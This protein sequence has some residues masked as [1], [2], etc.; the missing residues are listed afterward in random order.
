MQSFPSNYVG[1]ARNCTAARAEFQAIPP[2]QDSNHPKQERREESIECVC[3]FGAFVMQT[4]QREMHSF[5]SRYV[6]FE[7]NHAAAGAESQ[8]TGSKPSQPGKK[9]QSVE[10]VCRFGAFAMQT[11]HQ[12]RCSLSPAHMSALSAITMLQQGQNPKLSQPGKK[13]KSV[14]RCCIAVPCR[15]SNYPNQEGR[16]ESIECCCRFGTFAVQAALQGITQT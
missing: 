11:A 12:G 14:E 15:S 4:A 9:K 10:R 3:I 6:G 5:P 8:T 13:T 2:S 16:E 1:A 7:R